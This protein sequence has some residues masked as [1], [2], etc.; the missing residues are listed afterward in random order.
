MPISIVI[1][2]AYKHGGCM[3]SIGVIPRK[4]KG[5][6][7]PVRRQVSGH[8]YGY[9]WSLVVSICIGHGSTIDRLVRR[10]HHHPHRTNHGEFLWRS[11]WDEAAA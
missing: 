6:F 9:F 5:F 10:L 3:V 1:S 11:D 8:V 4:L 7:Q 2:D